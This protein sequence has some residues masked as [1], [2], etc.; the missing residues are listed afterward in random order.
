MKSLRCDGK[1]NCD[2]DS[3]TLPICNP[4]AKDQVKPPVPVSI[5]KK[6]EHQDLK[7]RHSDNTFSTP[8]LRLWARMIGS[9]IHDSLKTPPQ[10]LQ[11]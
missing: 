7:E 2:K 4:V 1:G 11:E 6:K 9:G 3:D 8:Q 10:V 5:R